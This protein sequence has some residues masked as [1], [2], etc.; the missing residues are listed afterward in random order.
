MKNK[1]KQQKSP[2]PNTPEELALAL[3]T[4][5][6]RAILASKKKGKRKTLFE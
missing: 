5:E 4:P 3:R 6:L 1:K 2:D